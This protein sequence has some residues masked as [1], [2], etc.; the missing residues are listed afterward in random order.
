MKATNEGDLDG[1]VVSKSDVPGC[2]SSI[3][4]RGCGGRDVP[5]GSDDVRLGVLVEPD[6][7]VGGLTVSYE[8]RYVSGAEGER[9]AAAQAKA[10]AALLRWRAGCSE[11][12]RS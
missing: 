11:D 7:V 9:V 3:P 2:G 6:A 5:A 8:V 12:G 10:I 1:A 4:D